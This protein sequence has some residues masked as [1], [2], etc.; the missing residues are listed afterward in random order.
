MDKELAI[1]DL[2]L[3]KKVFDKFNTPF[4]LAYGT[5]LGAYRDKD[6][7]PG[8]EDIDLV[9]TTDALSREIPF[10]TRKAIG[11]AL[12]DLGFRPQ[13][14]MFNVCG[15]MEM[16]Q[17]GYNGDHETGII[18]CERNVK[19]TIFFFKD[20]KC[21]THGDV[22]LCIPRLGAVKL[23]ESPAKFYKGAQEIKFKGE[24]FLVPSPIE[25]YLEFTYKDWKDKLARD[26]GQT[27]LEMHAKEILEDVPKHNEAAIFS[28]VTQRDVGS[29]YGEK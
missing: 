12:Y 13:E 4:Y 21:E 3:V 9:V 23:I 28:R 6:F 8:D 26:H 2:K 10:I 19:F 24:K 29:T 16:V 17:I 20:D 27:Y 11:W 22:K 25:E 1:S 7:L 18:V 15:R 5:A 14:V